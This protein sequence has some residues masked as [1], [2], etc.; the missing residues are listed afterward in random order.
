MPIPSKEQQYREL[1]TNGAEYALSEQV[2]FFCYFW[3]NFSSYF[4]GNDKPFIHSITD[5]CEKFK[6]F[7]ID[8]D[9]TLASEWLRF[10]ELH[11]ALSKVVTIAG[12][13]GVISE[14]KSCFEDLALSLAV[15]SPCAIND[16]TRTLFLHQRFAPV[17]EKFWQ[18]K[19]RLEQSYFFLIEHI[20]KPGNLSLLCNPGFQP[21]THLIP[22]SHNNGI[23]CYSVKINILYHSALPQKTFSMP[24]DELQQCQ[25]V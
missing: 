8:K 13:C 2:I 1:F 21:I 11:R 9:P 16:R 24:F 7:C 19:D 5:A 17:I 10:I 4:N 6:E 25:A 3:L 15:K 20:E 12:A 22:L 14:F 18:Q 23:L